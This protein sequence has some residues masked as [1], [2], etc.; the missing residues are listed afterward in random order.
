MAVC[1]ILTVFVLNT[2]T[3]EGVGLPNYIPILQVNPGGRTDIIESLFRLGL[4]YTDILCISCQFHGIIFSFRQLKRILKSK[5]LGR[6][7]SDLREVFPEPAS[8]DLDRNSSKVTKRSP[9]KSTEK[10]TKKS[11]T[12]SPKK[13]PKKSAWRLAVTVTQNE[14]RIN[15]TMSCK[16]KVIPEYVVRCFMLTCCAV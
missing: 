15:N 9:Q 5:G 12:K 6:Y 3:S 2:S 1:V 10:S 16:L 14:L 11:T 7:P 13:S 4:Y 8:K